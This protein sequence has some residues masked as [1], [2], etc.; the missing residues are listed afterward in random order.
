[1]KLQAFYAGTMKPLFDRYIAAGTAHEMAA[2]LARN[3][4][5][6]V[7][8]RDEKGNVHGTYNRQQDRRKR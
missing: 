1:M 5:K 8:L 2:R 3:N 7:V 6:E 4:D